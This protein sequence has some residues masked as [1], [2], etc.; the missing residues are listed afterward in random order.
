LLTEKVRMMLPVYFWRC[1]GIRLG[2]S[3][4]D[5]EG[6]TKQRKTGAATRKR[7]C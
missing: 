7:C 3:F 5:E 2:S 6:L 4:G 1:T